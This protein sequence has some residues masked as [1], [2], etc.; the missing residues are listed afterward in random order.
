LLYRNLE[1]RY[2]ERAQPLARKEIY[3]DFF[4]I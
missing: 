1:K 3:A 2:T 4:V